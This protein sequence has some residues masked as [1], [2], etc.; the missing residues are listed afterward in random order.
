LR[1]VARARSQ[2]SV[3][4]LCSPPGL[5][6]IPSTP[7]GLQLQEVW[8]LTLREILEIHRTAARPASAPA[9]KC[10][11]APSKVT[12][13]SDRAAS[14]RSVQLRGAPSQRPVQWWCSPPGLPG[15]P[16]T[17][18]CL[19]IYTRPTSCGG[20]IPRQTASRYLRTRAFLSSE[21]RGA[22]CSPAPGEFAV[23]IIP[24]DHRG[25]AGG[26]RQALSGTSRATR[27]QRGPR[28][29]GRG[30]ASGLC[31]GMKSASFAR[32]PQAG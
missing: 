10:T 19:G 4:W 12:A 18:R 23:Q 13:G 25:S 21:F 26:V 27:H 15:I 7:R 8:A 1:E 20:L 30:G 6:G 29:L 16:S 31:H 2:R 14:Q 9:P 22:P 5:P 32:D 17:P 11:T 24:Q 28:T 3:Q